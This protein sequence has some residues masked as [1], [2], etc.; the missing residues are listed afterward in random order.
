MTHRGIFK[1]KPCKNVIPTS[2]FLG[3]IFVSFT[4]RGVFMG[5][6]AG[7]ECHPLLIFWTNKCIFRQKCPFLRQNLSI[8][9]Q[10]WLFLGKSLYYDKNYYFSHKNCHFLKNTKKLLTFLKKCYNCDFWPQSST[11]CWSR[12]ITQNV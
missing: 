4:C 1:W 9:R 6:G 2:R 7:A 12:E 8:F 10:S 11:L 3:Q 5:G